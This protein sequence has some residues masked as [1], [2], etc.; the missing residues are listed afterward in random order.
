L[1]ADD[2]TKLSDSRENLL[3]S[4]QLILTVFRQVGLICPVGHNGFKSK[5]EAM[6]SPATGLSCQDS[7]TNPLEIDG[8]KAPFT[9]NLNF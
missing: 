2:K 5:D 1:Y 3:K 4:L 8:G 6:Y 7:D 9:L